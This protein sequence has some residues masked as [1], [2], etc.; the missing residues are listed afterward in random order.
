MEIRQIAVGLR[1]C[2]KTR[3]KPFI[4]SDFPE[5]FGWT[6]AAF[7][8]MTREEGQRYFGTLKLA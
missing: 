3:F 8:P 1:R 2:G 4:D 5:D 7:E 6:A